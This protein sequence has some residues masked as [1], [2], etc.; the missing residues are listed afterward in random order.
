MSHLSGTESAKRGHSVCKSLDTV[1]SMIGR[2]TCPEL[3]RMLL[4]VK[5]QQPAEGKSPSGRDPASSLSIS[6]SPCSDSRLSR[7]LSSAAGA[8]A[9]L[10]HVHVLSHMQTWDA[11]AWKLPHEALVSLLARPTTTPHP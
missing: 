7:P 2:E 6:L 4:E 10:P 5:L 11:V 9:Y 3:G 1:A 8:P